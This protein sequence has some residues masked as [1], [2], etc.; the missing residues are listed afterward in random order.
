[1]E[2]NV[3]KFLRDINEEMLE[4]PIPIAPHLNYL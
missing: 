1:M 2:D 3:K 4:Q